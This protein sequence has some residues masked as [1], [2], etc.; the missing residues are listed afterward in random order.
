MHHYGTGNIII[1]RSTHQILSNILLQLY[2]NFFRKLSLFFQKVMHNI[3]LFKIWQSAQGYSSLLCLLFLFA[4]WTLIT[5]I[6]LSNSFRLHNPQK[7]HTYITLSIYFIWLEHTHLFSTSYKVYTLIYEKH[8]YENVAAAQN[9][10]TAFTSF[11]LEP[12]ATIPH[13]DVDK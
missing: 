1:N 7:L 12:S 8:I 11:F 2:L 13:A 4:S 10:P 5:Y 3:N 9:V 6:T